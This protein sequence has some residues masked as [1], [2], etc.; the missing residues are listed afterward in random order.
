MTLL[1][2][3]IA[4]L[5]AGFFSWRCGEMATSAFK[6]Q[7]FRVQIGLQTFIQPTLAS[8]NAAE[9]KNAVVAY[10]ILGAL[11]G[12]AMGIAGGLTAQLPSRGLITGLGG[13]VVVAAIAAAA[14]Y[15]LLPLFYR[16]HVPDPNDWW[17]PLVIHGGIW[18]AVGAASGL[19]FAIGRRSIAYAPRVIFGA[20][21]GAVLA[22]FLFQAL[23][24]QFLLNAG[25][26]EPNARTSSA[27]LLA[28]LLVCGFIAVGAARGTRV[29]TEAKAGPPSEV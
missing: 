29:R 28:R 5:A 15:G 2:T 8:E 7:L 14:S 12:L 9:F 23:A 11:T 16:R 22:T 10:M 18:T 21:V 3:L 6:P 26:D 17:S 20:S 27:R 19:F 1:V 13:A 25:A 4:G 24:A